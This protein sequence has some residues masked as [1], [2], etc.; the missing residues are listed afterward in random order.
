MRRAIF[1]NHVVLIYIIDAI[2]PICDD[3]GIIPGTVFPVVFGSPF[4]FRVF[5]FVNLFS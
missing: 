3:P 2:M 1:D 5:I 4:P